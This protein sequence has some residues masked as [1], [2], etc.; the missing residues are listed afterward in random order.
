MSGLGILPNGIF[1]EAFGANSDGSVVVG[2]SA[3]PIPSSPDFAPRAFRWA[4][5]SMVELS[6]PSQCVNPS[7]GSRVFAVDATGHVVVGGVFGCGQNQAIR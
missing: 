6:L 3:V 5:G 2:T 1:S 7:D 4:G